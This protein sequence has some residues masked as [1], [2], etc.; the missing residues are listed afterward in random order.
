MRTRSLG[1]LHTSIKQARYVQG[2]DLLVFCRQ[3]WT[4]FACLPCFACCKSGEQVMMQSLSY[5]CQCVPPFSKAHWLSVRIAFQWS[6]NQQ[7]VE[8]TNTCSHLPGK[9]HVDYC[10][11]TLY[12][13][14]LDTIPQ[15]LPWKLFETLLGFKPIIET[16]PGFVSFLCLMCLPLL[17]TF[18]QHQSS[19][20]VGPVLTIAM[21]HS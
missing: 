18:L 13:L 12:L 20:H 19:Y 16:T 2:Y 15:L 7:Q 3:V 5:Q 8:N 17:L 4:C 6:H 1:A 9:Y 21:V 11:G 14:R 10:E